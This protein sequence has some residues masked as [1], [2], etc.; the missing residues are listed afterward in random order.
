MW[1][2]EA[3][4]FIW[5]V[6]LEW[7][8]S[9]VCMVPVNKTGNPTLPCLKKPREVTVR[10]WVILIYQAESRSMQLPSIAGWR[11]GEVTA[12]SQR[13]VPWISCTLPPPPQQSDTGTTCIISWMGQPCVQWMDHCFLFSIHLELLLPITF[14]GWTQVLALKEGRKSTLPVLHTMNNFLSV[15]NLQGHHLRAK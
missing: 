12:D 1:K 5:K 14:P 9:I 4:S 13:R 11:A 8:S 3:S 6:P 2:C 15:C 7:E 10:R